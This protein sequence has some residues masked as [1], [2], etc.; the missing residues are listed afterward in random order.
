MNTVLRVSLIYAL[1]PLSLKP[2]G[3]DDVTSYELTPLGP[4]S[5]QTQWK[6]TQQG[7][8]RGTLIK[9][10]KCIRI[11]TIGGRS[12]QSCDHTVCRILYDPESE[13]RDAHVPKTVYSTGNL[14]RHFS[15][16]TELLYL[17]TLV[18]GSDWNFPVYGTSF[19]EMRLTFTN[20]NIFQCFQCFPLRLR[21]EP[22]FSLHY[23]SFQ[24]IKRFFSF[25]TIRHAIV[26]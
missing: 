14:E 16:V 25:H 5:F 1:F 4:S 24:Y 10:R 3:T 23:L 9:H 13:L 21:V 2:D 8:V 17:E 18:S 19:G 22:Y 6:P 12:F 15:V 26:L 11:G 20:L 7:V